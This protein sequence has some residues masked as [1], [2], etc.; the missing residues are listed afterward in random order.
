[1]V[2]LIEEIQR[3]ALNEAMPVDALLRRVKLAAAKLKLPALESWVESELNG[4]NGALPEYRKVHGQVSAWNPYNGWI[5][6]HIGDPRLSDMVSEARIA[7]SIATIRDLA[8]KHQGGLLHLPIPDGQVALLNEMMNF[9]TARMVIQIGRGSII[10]ILNSVRNQVLDW[11]IE[12]EKQGVIGDGMSFND[13]EKEQARTVMNKFEIGS[14]GTFAGNM[15]SD[16]SSGD[17]SVSAQ[18]SSQILEVVRKVR[19]AV[20]QLEQDGADVPRLTRAMDQIEQETAKPAPDGGRLKGLLADAREA[21]VG[22]AGSLTAEGAM[23]LIMAAIKLFG[24]P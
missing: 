1:M 6:V 4:Y 20:V 3:D 24:S 21:L 12:M 13:R 17:I 16:N 2:G 10:G 15:G 19:Q 11:A 5:P 22:A 8:E 14:I 7:Q 18:T 9:Q 23:A